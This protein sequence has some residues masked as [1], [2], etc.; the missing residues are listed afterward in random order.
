MNCGKRVQRLSHP[1]ESIYCLRVCSET[2]PMLDMK[3]PSVQKVLAFQKCRRKLAAG[4]CSQ[5]IAFTPPRTEETCG[6]RSC[7]E[8]KMLSPLR[9]RRKQDTSRSRLRLEPFTPPR[10]EETHCRT[11]LYICNLLSPL[12]GRRKQL[13]MP[14]TSA[15][16]SFTPPRT[17][18]THSSFKNVVIVDFHPSADGGNVGGR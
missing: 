2:S 3:Y 4:P 12:R 1:C 14:W 10:T 9:G 15:F 8:E 18:E 7:T 13:S 6:A 5:F 17:E 11:F 16:W